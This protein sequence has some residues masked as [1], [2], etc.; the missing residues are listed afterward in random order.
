MFQLLDP[1]YLTVIRFWRALYSLKLK[2]DLY[3]PGDSLL[4]YIATKRTLASDYT[5]I[6]CIFLA[7][8]LILNFS[9]GKSVFSRPTAIIFHTLSD[10]LRQL[11]F[12][13][14]MQL[15]LLSFRVIIDF[16]LVYWAPTR[17]KTT[18]TRTSIISNTK[19]RVNGRVFL[20]FFWIVLMLLANLV[21]Y[22]FNF[23]Y[24]MSAFK[25]LLAR[26]MWLYLVSSSKSLVYVWR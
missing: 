26:E 24:Y 13:C 12:F 4:S 10:H 22:K 7:R 16:V 8:D 19:I 20:D 21:L 14:L 17:G 3:H 1:N 15:L 9:G 23:L 18:C 25:S 6:I 11:P 2:K 5:D